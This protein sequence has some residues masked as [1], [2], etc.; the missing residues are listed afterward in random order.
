MN[1]ADGESAKT[2]KGDGDSIGNR[3]D[4]QSRR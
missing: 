4:P 1:I 2:T 3:T